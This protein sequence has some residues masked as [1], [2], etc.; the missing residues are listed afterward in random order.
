MI[1]RVVEAWTRATSS[2]EAAIEVI[3]Q[4]APTD[5][6]RPPK[7][8]IRLASQTARKTRCCR[9]ARGDALGP[10][11]SAAGFLEA[12]ATRSRDRSVAMNRRSRRRGP[13]LEHDGLPLKPALRLSP[14]PLQRGDRAGAAGEDT[15][16][17]FFEGLDQGRH[18]EAVRV[19]EA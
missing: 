10:G 13:T 16:F 9:G 2:A 15:P 5:W 8:E 6:I 4:E 11:G 1:G 17:G 18:V 7:F 3:S 19:H 14:D 12:S